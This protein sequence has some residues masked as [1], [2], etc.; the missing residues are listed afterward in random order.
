MMIHGP[1]INLGKEAAWQKRG[2]SVLVGGLYN[3]FIISSGQCIAGIAGIGEG[4]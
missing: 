4:I 3:A 2:P 1:Q